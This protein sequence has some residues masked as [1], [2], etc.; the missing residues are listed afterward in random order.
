[1]I[2]KGLNLFTPHPPL[3]YSRGCG[4]EEPFCCELCKGCLFNIGRL[5][6]K[7]RKA[8]YTEMKM[9]RFKKILKQANAIR[10]ER[11]KEKERNK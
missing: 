3:F 9:E 11:E 7:Y 4:L 6:C 1:M 2:K 5:I 10:E 8:Y